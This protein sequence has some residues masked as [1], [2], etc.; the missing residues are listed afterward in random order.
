MGLC[1]KEWLLTQVMVIWRARIQT[2]HLSVQQK[3]QINFD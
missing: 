2:N 3:R 1:Y